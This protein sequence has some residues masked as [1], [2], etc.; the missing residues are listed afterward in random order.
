LLEL[1]IRLLEGQ[2]ICLVIFT[3]LLPS[4]HC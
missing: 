2:K 4:Q 3:V 1:T